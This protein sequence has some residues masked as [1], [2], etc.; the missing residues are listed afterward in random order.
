MANKSYQVMV[1]G[2]PEIRNKGTTIDPLM[3]KVGRF[4]DEQG[5]GFIII[6]PPQLYGQS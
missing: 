1:C 2:E 6:S 3:K 5:R 4:E